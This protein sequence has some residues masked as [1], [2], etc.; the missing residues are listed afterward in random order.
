MGQ[1][2]DGHS[3]HLPSF[4]AVMSCFGGLAIGI[5]NSL[6]IRILSL[7]KEF[8]YPFMEVALIALEGQ[9]IVPREKYWTK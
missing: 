9:D 5:L 6:P 1:L 2:V 4:G 8:L 3:P 7:L